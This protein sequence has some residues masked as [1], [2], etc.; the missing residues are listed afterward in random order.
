[1]WLA[2]IV[3]SCDP[4]EFVNLIRPDGCE[5][6]VTERGAFKARGTFMDIGRLYAQRRCERLSRIVDVDMPQSGIVFLTEPGPSLYWDG[7]EIA[8]EHVAL[9]SAGNSYR[10]R[11]SG[12]TR[13]GSLSLSRDDM[14]QIQASYLGQTARLISGCT[15]IAPPPKALAHLRLL[16]AAAGNLAE[17]FPEPT[18]FPGSESAVE[19]ALI[20]AMLECIGAEHVNAGTTA[21]QHHRLVARRFHELAAAYPLG[22][23]HLPEISRS[24]GVSGRTLRLACQ[25]QF[26]VSPT[27]Y[28]LLRR[29]RS[30]RRALRQA[31]PELTRV[32]DVATDL[33]F[34]ELGRFSVKYREIFG[35]SPST[36][37]R[38]AASLNRH[39]A[40]PDYAVA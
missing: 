13:W 31:D 36:T 10:S 33:G 40:Q 19:Q 39:L 12:P 26:G 35:E 30:A 34:W 28:L 29:M 6:L 18:I 2:R 38:A 11:L 1:M 37:L 20:Q 24:I 22:P 27:Q 25:E 3:E 21:I 14:D 15:I 23:L 17:A 5:L 8:Y 16:H 9:F 32:T 4:D 7:A